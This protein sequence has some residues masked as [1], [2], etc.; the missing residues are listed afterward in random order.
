MLKDTPK[1]SNFH[2]DS[3][4]ISFIKFN[5]CHQKLRAWEN[6]PYFG[7]YGETPPKSQKILMTHSSTVPGGGAASYKLCPEFTYSNGYREVYRRFQG[8]LF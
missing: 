6:L 4:Y 7:K 1:E 2:A 3:K 8:N 5:L